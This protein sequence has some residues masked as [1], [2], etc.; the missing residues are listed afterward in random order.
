M[1]VHIKC[2]VRI[3]GVKIMW[4]S[5]SFLS[6]DYGVN[7]PFYIEYVYVMATEIMKKTVRQIFFYR[8][9]IAMIFLFFK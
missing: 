1:L 5:L 4:H 8:R 9:Q 7:V 3:S 6:L 2:T